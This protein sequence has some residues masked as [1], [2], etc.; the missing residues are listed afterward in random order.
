MKLFKRLLKNKFLFEELVS[1]DFKEKYKRTIL[2]VGW[3]ILSPL[4][5]L[6][7][8]VL[9]F[10][11]LLGRDTPHY[12]IY[13]FCGTL[14][15][16]YYRE[17]TKLG[18]K[19]L[20]KNRSIINKIN[21]PK[22]MFLLSNNVS[23]LINF[24]ITLCVFFVLCLFDHISFGWYFLILFY[25]IACLAIFN[26]GIGLILSASYVFFRDTGYLYDILLT[27]INYL[28]AI[29]YRI[30]SFSIGVQNLFLCNPLY[31]YIRYFR[32]VVIDGRIPSLQL[33]GLC[34]LYAVL[35]LL[36][37]SLI[38]KKYNHTFIYYM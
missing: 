5:N 11:K 21:I 26:V 19:S 15:M 33:H 34:L 4:L 25:A 3:S 10:T 7:V 8:L 16:T 37:G 29:F 20:M 18:M 17:S 35:S 14:I 27:F 13:I 2:G 23:C 24:F 22:Y 12:S 1:R 36:I 31:C 28:S 32:D 6:L 38:Y 30:D 9:I